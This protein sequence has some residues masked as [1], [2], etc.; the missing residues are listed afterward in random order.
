MKRIGSGE[1]G[2][3]VAYPRQSSP[4]RKSGYRGT[5]QFLKTHFELFGW[6]MSLVSESYFYP[7]LDVLK[8]YT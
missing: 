5:R 4:S 8:H 1:G 7:A 6:Q 3:E 2:G